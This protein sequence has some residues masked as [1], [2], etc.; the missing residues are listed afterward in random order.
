MSKQPG[1]SGRG[2]RWGL[3]GALS[4]VLVAMM[5]LMSV[6]VALAK[7]PTGDFAVFKQC[8]RFTA[9]VELCLYAT[10]KSGSVT[11]GSTTVPINEDGKHPII[12]QGGIKETEGKQTFVP[13]LNG[14]TL[15]KTPQKVPGG[16]LDLVKC[17]EIKGEGWAEKGLRFS[18]ELI[19]ENSITGVN[20]VTELAGEVKIST[21]NLEIKEGAA[22][23]LPVK[24]RLENSLLG[25]EC[26]IGSNS[27]PVVLALTDGTTKPNPPNTP[28]T[29]KA[30]FLT[31]KDEFE[32]VEITENTLVNNEFAAPEA[33]GCGGIF[34]FL[35]DPIV[36]SKLGLP[37]ANGHNTAIE[38][39][40]IDEGGTEATI[41]SE[42]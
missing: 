12:L 5:G 20:A 39:N 36:D 27:N 14:E 25:S 30:G 13:A 11:I 26:Y 23:T 6:S 19:F 34:S 21:H 15:S 31:F 2:R 35:L 17:N 42:K 32:F 7:E 41:K 33:T 40:T 22:L 3:K 10:T 9:G 18:C 24:V 37:S 1:R 28:I 4:V 16:L 8:P 38:N 29:G